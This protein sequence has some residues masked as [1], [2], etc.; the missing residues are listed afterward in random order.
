M[1][2]LETSKNAP[3][4]SI[5]PGMTRK[6]R[7]AAKKSMIILDQTVKFETLAS[8]STKNTL[9][10]PTLYPRVPKKQTLDLKNLPQLRCGCEPFLWTPVE[11]PASKTVFIDKNG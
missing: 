2:F 11:P 1:T 7:Q 6:R 8:K 10:K 9:L 5:L 4:N 3:N